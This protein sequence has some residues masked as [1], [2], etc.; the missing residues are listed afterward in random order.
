MNIKRFIP[1]ILAGFMCAFTLNTSA[2]DSLQCKDLKIHNTNP[3]NPN[4]YQVSFLINDA[5]QADSAQLVFGTAKGRDDLFSE[6]YPFACNNGNCYLIVNE[7]ERQITR[8]K[9]WFELTLTDA[10]LS[11]ASYAT[12]YVFK[13]GPKAITLYYRLK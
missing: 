6:S 9:A 1:V 11:N 2:A 8:Y 4:H 12:L 3:E 10:V 5:S 13:A 7:Q